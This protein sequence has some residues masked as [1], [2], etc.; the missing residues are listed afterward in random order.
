[1]LLIAIVVVYIDLFIKF[2]SSLFFFILIIG[3]VS[4]RR[5]YNN[6]KFEL[7]KYRSEI[8]E[9]GSISILFLLLIYI[10]Y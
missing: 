4:L 8:R 7:F 1:M 2:S 6:L 5:D 10:S 9:L 3:S